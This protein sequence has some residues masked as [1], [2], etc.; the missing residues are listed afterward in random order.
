MKQK[1]HKMEKELGL[2]DVFSI[3]AGAMISYFFIHRSLGPLFGTFA[4]LA[5]WFSIALKSAFALVGIGIFLTPLIPGS[6]EWIIKGIAIGFTLVF[7]VLNL[8]SVKESGRSQIILVFILLSILIIYIVTAVPKVELSNFNP[9]LKDG[10]HSLLQTAGLIFISFGGLTKIA[11]VAEEVK[12]PGKVL[13]RGMFLAFGVVTVL[14][15]GAVFVTTGLLPVEALGKTLTPLSDGAAVIAGKTGYIILSIAA[16]SAFITTANAGLMAAS[17]TPLAMA[18]D[19]LLPPFL[20]KVSLKFKTP[21]TAILTT[22]AFMILVILFLDIDKLIKTASTMMLILFIMVNISV[23]LMRESKIS[24][25]RPKYKAPFYPFL[26][27]IGIIVY[28]FLIFE[29]GTVPIVITGLFFLASLVWYLIYSRKRNSQDS[30]LIH[31]VERITSKEIKS[32]GLALELKEILMERDEIIEDRF[33][34]II[35][36]APIIDIPPEDDNMDRDQLFRLLAEKLSKRVNKKSEDIF[37]RLEKR[38][39]ESTTMIS[40][41]LA[42]PHII[43]EDLDHFEIIVLRSKKG[44]KFTKDGPLVNTVFTLAGNKEDR[45]FHLQALMAIAQ[46]VQNSEFKN[47]WLKLRTESELKNLILLTDRIRKGAV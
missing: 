8:L 24:T 19:N 33:D 44:I 36:D 40:E 18:E 11:S 13:P 30:A 23:V 47:N 45:T 25:Y 42:I 38:E 6:N 20:G 16:M 3:A 46:I 22:S 21:V 2:L 43:L 26:Q 35:K 39:A 5:G 14:Y 31:I 29:M 15:I 41:G 32:S 12:N 7:T 4:G 27:I 17:R 9:L 34:N 1:K 37:D 10:W 28:S